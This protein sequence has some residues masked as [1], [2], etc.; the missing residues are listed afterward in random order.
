MGAIQGP[1]LLPNGG[2]MMYGEPDVQD[3]F[4]RIQIEDDDADMSS[5]VTDVKVNISASSS[6]NREVPITIINSEKSNYKS[7]S[8]KKDA[9]G[10]SASAVVT[11]AY[12]LEKTLLQLQRDGK[13]LAKFVSGLKRKSLVSMLSK[14]PQLEPSVIYLLLK[15]IS[16]VYGRIKGNW[17]KVVDW[18]ESISQLTSF[19]LLFQ[20]MVTEERLELQQLINHALLMII[21]TGE[22]VEVQD[23]IRE[24]KDCLFNRF[25]I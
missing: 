24:R 10:A 15:A 12:E 13:L 20:L 3:G 17:T 5:E 7:H 11:G 4:Q 16:E 19:K 18:Y 2:T 21:E 23:R 25:E 22:T 1:D 8:S 14:S 9:A 6:S